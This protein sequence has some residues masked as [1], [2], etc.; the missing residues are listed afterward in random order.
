[1]HRKIASPLL[2][3]GVSAAFI[4]GISYVMR[5]KL[6]DAAATLQHGVQWRWFIAAFLVYLAAQIILPIR[7]LVLLRAHHI[8]LPLG[9]AIVLNFCGL[10]FN[11]FLP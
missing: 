1:M 3:L 4:A 10:F 7:L 2:R 11:L 6:H 8:H 9:K 5:D